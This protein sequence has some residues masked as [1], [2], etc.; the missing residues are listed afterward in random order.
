MILAGLVG[1]QP[2]AARCVSLDAH[3]KGSAGYDASKKPIALFDW[4]NTVIKNDV[5]DMTL[6]W[7]LKMNKIFQPPDKKLAPD[8]LHYESRCTPRAEGMRQPGQ[9]RRSAADRQARGRG[10][11][12]AI[13]S[14]YLDNKGKTGLAAF[15]GYDYRRMEPTYAWAVQLQAYSPAEISLMA[16]DALSPRPSPPSSTPPR[17]SATRQVNAYLR[18][19]DQMKDLIGAMRDNGIEVWVINATSEPVVRAFSAS[20][21]SPTDRIVGVRMVLD[22]GGKQTYNL[23]GQ[24]RCARR[25]EQR[26]GDLRGQ[27]DHAVH[28]RQALAGEQG[29]LRGRKPHCGQPAARGQAPIFAAG[30]SSTDVALCATR[31]SSSWC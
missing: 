28:R 19:Y 6:F 1:R 9:S 24:G 7:M 21:G 26:R 23:Q 16:K 2:Q 11:A 3:G 8:E 13:L 20:V 29:D 27:L 4:D 15:G 25:P 18:V 14:V 31:R 5:G 22:P 12:D 30:D 10:R 17:P